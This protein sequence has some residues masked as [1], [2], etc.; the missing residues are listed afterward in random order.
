M[1]KVSNHLA[2]LN[3][4]IIPMSD[5]KKYGI[6]FCIVVYLISISPAKYIL[7]INVIPKEKVAMEI[8][9]GILCLFLRNNIPEYIYTIHNV[10]VEQS[11]MM[12]ICMFVNLHTIVNMSPNVNNNKVPIWGKNFVCRSDNIAIMIEE[13]SNSLINQKG[14]INNS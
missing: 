5:R 11:P 3:V 8:L 10:N 14:R 1:G 4:I 12:G 7:P 9:N 13:K 2:M 6:M